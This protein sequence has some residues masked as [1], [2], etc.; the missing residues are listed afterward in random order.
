MPNKCRFSDQECAGVANERGEIICEGC[1]VLQS[2]MA[3]T[4]AFIRQW[5]PSNLAIAAAKDK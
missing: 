3:R 5:K 1:K 2:K 4:R